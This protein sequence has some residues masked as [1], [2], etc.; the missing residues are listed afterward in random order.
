MTLPTK[1]VVT[2]AGSA[3]FGENTLSALM[4]SR[5]LCGSTIALV[6]RNPVSLDIV[7]R[8]ANRLNGEWDAEMTIIAHTHH[9]EALDGASFVVSAIEVGAREGLWRKDHEI[10]LKY[11]VRSPYSE[12]GG[13]GGFAHA[14]RNVGPVMEIIRDMQ[15][16]CPDAWFV[17]FTNPMIRI[18]DAVNRHSSIKAVGLCHQIYAGY[19]M[20]GVALAKDYGIEIP[21]ELTGMHAAIDQFAAHDAIK[22]RIVPLVDIRAAGLN[23]FSWILS[24]RDRKTGEDLYPLFRKRFFELD[25]S[26]EPLTRDVYEAFGIFP[27]P[28]DTHLCE[29]LPWV[30]DPQTRPWERYNIR[31][32]DWDMMANLRDFGLDR[33]NDMASGQLT[34]D[35]LR[36]TDSEGALEMIEN[37]AAAGTHYHLAANLRNEG[38]I[39]NLPLDATVE[40]PVV[41][42]G[43]G[44][45]PVYVGSLP[46][47]VAELCRREI[48][49][50]QLCVD[51]AVEGSR[52]KA[53]QCLLLDPVITDIGTSRRILDEYLVTYKEY[54]PQYQ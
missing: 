28:G 50:A 2:G 41:V 43:A 13:P 47:P 1:I 17:N 14:A 48:T 54:L 11:G 32:Y 44:I 39:S 3:S 19:T 38:Q 36:E 45:H 51:S 27:V 22:R 12:N 10:P 24:I 4:R 21:P 53:L 6:D 9:E 37:V 35:G 34:V 26:F 30:S 16:Q 5:R 49:A 7:K 25:P 20:V 23:H 40:T 18:C 8:L 46:A 52:Q 31:L 33:L 29:Y 42:D 15:R